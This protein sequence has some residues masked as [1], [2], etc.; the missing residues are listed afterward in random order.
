MLYKSVESLAV[1]GTGVTVK[2]GFIAIN[3]INMIGRNR[4]TIIFVD[5][6]VRNRDLER[7]RQNHKKVCMLMKSGTN[8]KFRAAKNEYISKNNWKKP[9]RGF[10]SKLNPVI[11]WR[12]IR[13]YT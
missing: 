8:E 4:K 13:R 10:W 1:T 3:E 6:S 5:E 7:P 2:D 11:E 9:R 12:I